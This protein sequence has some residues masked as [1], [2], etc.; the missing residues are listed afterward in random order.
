MLAVAVL[1]ACSARTGPEIDAWAPERD[2]GYPERFLVDAAVW[3]DVREPGVVKDAHGTEASDA[4]S[5]DAFG[6]GGADGGAPSCSY[7]AG[8]A[9]TDAAVTLD[10]GDAAVAVTCARDEACY[11]APLMGAPSGRT[12]CALEGPGVELSPCVSQDD[13]D[14]RHICDGVGDG[15][16]LC[17]VRCD[18]RNPVLCPRGTQCWAF[19]QFLTAGLCR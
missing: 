5:P 15:S 18:P 10:G 11:P 4:R 13:C 19:P 8:F 7:L 14:G 12:L 17:R 6:D 1:G 3:A 9:S 16:G 2:G